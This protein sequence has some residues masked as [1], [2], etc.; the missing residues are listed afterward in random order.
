MQHITIR[1]NTV[2][3]WT[4]Y[5]HKGY[6]QSKLDKVNITTELIIFEIGSDWIG[7]L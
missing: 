6:F 7:L 2:D 4:T 3:F 5:L 1:I